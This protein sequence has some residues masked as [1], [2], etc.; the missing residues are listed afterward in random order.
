MLQRFLG[1]ESARP[2]AVALLQWC[3][4]PGADSS[5]KL[6]PA[7]TRID[8]ARWLGEAAGTAGAMVLACVDAGRTA[9]ALALGL[10]CGVMYARAGQGQ[11]ALGQ[12]GIRLERFVGD[13]HVGVVEGRGWSDAAETVI[14]VAGPD[15][16]R[17]A[18]DRADALL[19]ELRVG[20][21]AHLIDMLPS[22]LDQRKREFAEAPSI[23]I[24][25]PAEV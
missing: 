14:R 15:S 20:D 6:L 13:R 12:A 25:A 11:A 9:D 24:A 16:M 8:L 22:A 17:G 23:H 10:V 19:N 18:L 4:A 3:T 21:F 1:L 5:L 7:A 2:D